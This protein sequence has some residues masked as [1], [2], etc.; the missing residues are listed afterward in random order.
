MRIGGKGEERSCP[1]GAEEGSFD[2]ELWGARSILTQ[3]SGLTEGSQVSTMGR[4]G[5]KHGL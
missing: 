3:G 5:G 1:V 2:Q 4:I